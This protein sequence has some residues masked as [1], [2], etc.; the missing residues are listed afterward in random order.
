MGDKRMFE[1]SDGSSNKFWE[2]W[3]EGDTV[4]TRFGKIG[5]N[6]QTKIKEEADPEAAIE[7][8]IAEKTKKGYSEVGAAKTKSATKTVAA[9]KT[10]KRA[11]V[12][13][14]DDADDEGDVASFEP[15][16]PRR[17]E[18]STKFWEI[19]VDGSS[20]TVRFGKLGAAGQSKTKTF[21]D[22]DAARA[23][24]TKLIA[25]KT[26]KGYDEVRV[27]AAPELDAKELKQHLKNLPGLVQDPGFLV[28]SDWLQTKNHPWGQLIALQHAA[29]TT[30]KKAAS[31]QKE[32]EK[33]LADQ[34]AAILGPLARARHSDFTWHLGFLRRAV[35]GMEADAKS[36]AAGVKALLALP[37]AHFLEALVIN[38]YVSSFPVWRDWDSSLDHVVDPWDDLEKLAKLIPERIKHVGFGGWPAPA[39]TAYVQMP[40]F[41]KLSKAFPAL[42]RLELT[43]H[44]GA[45]PG[46]LSLGKL[47]DLEV[48]FARGDNNHLE[49][50]AGSKLPKLERLVVWLGG[51]SH[52]T[53]DDV[54]PPD[55]DFDYDDEDA[56]GLDR[57]PDSFSDGDLERMSSY[58][59]YARA[60]AD[61]VGALLAASYSPSLTHLGI[62]SAVFDDAMVAA[63]VKS[64]LIKRIKTLD[65]SGGTLSD[66]MVKSFV[67]AKKALG[68]LESID[69]SRNKLTAAG[70]KKL[71]AALPN[72][73]IGKPGKDPSGPEF[74][75]R[76][77]AT[78]E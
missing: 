22:A 15:G 45:K 48:R 76:F 65:L 35:V 49:A 7:K 4:Y 18:H 75:F 20:H 38:P 70:A 31:L 66:E 52:V 47:V 59:T 37:I 19:V 12:E 67:S 44:G 69:V 74:H 17:F 43:G 62:R 11:A 30:P 2:I 14:D 39:A 64:P 28:F 29:A 25:E 26:G 60:N 77:V 10:T 71:V 68:H 1:L 40:S 55:D 23:D 78:V 32:A 63:I 36:I 73:N 13:E 8:Q 42:E 50:I 9:K 46:K 24:A 57:Y 34:R 58:G 6:G 41:S 61:A 56:T 27:A 51:E 33:L 5:S 3:A 16:V 54:Y 53:V 21:D 72:A